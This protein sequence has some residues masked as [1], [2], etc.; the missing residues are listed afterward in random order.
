MAWCG[1][2]ETYNRAKVQKNKHHGDTIVAFTCKA[3]RSFEASTALTLSASH[4]FSN[5][6]V[7]CLR[8]SLSSARCFLS[9]SPM[10]TA[11]DGDNGDD[12]GGPE[13]GTA[14]EQELPLEGAT[15]PPVVAGAR[16]SASR[17]QS[18]F[19]YQSK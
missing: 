15:V 13:A 18:R 16:N 17:L 7:A 11:G 8:A 6:A 3:I 14:A 19:S 12:G 10:S 2:A 1:D 9:S 4:F 5:S